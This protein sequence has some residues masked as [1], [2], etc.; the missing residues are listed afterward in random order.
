MLAF[1]R[2]L[3]DRAALSPAARPSPVREQGRPPSGNGASSMHLMWEGAPARFVAARATVTVPVAP[4]TQDLYFFAL[5]VSFVAGG[6]PVGGGH[7]GLQW[8]QRH[9]NGRAV[10][11]GGYASQERGGAV[12]AGTESQLP[13]LP[14]DPNTRDYDW[15]PGRSYR[16]EVEPAPE[17]GW[18]RG[19]VT[20]LAAGER[21]VIRD[22]GGGG[23][24][25]TSAMVWAE[26]F[27]P[28][29]ASSVTVRWRDLEI[30]TEPG[31]WHSVRAV[32]VNYQDYTAGGCTNTNATTDG[33]G[34]SQTT[35]VARTTPQ[36][37]R[38]PVATT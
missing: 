16:L 10:N 3:F 11:W 38:L 8:N 13:S 25:L 19:S 34:W 35:A 2:S 9:T 29:D 26:V 24:Q 6:R 21:T 20:D 22:L 30:A 28:C 36:G 32:A 18:W 23:D 15:Q 27:A 12:L 4:A 5:Q 17:R 33:V 31:R 7:V 14:D 1:I 37:T